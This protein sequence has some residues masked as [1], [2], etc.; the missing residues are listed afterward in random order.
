[1]K[2][3]IRVAVIVISLSCLFCLP[4]FGQE[5]KINS[6]VKDEVTKQS[7]TALQLIK[8]AKEKRYDSNAIIDS[9]L[10]LSPQEKVKFWLKE[11]SNKSEIKDAMIVAGLDAVPYLAD[12]VRYGKGEQ[13]SDA[14]EILCYMDR[15]I[16]D[17]DLLLPVFGR[18]IYVK[19]L[20]IRGGINDYLPIDGRRIGNEGVDV[21]KWAAE[22]TEDKALNFYARYF[23]GRLLEELRSTPIREVYH[24]WR[25]LVIKGKGFLS[26]AINIDVFR[27]MFLCGTVLAENAPETLPF[28]IEATQ[29]KNPYIRERAI[30]VIASIDG[31][32]MRLRKSE[33]GKR[34]IEAVR[35]AL[36]QGNLK[37]MYI[38]RERREE[39]WQW[40][41][42]HIF[43][44]N[45]PLHYNSLWAIYALAM[46]TFYGVKTTDKDY[47]VTLIVE[48][49]PEFR[50]FITYLTDIDP[51]F[52]SWDFYTTG[53]SNIQ[54]HPR[55]RQ[56]VAHL[57]EYWKKFKAQQK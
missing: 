43:E 56:K 2:S 54:A 31:I 55:F 14:V 47:T 19:P 15:F 26:I 51:Y 39:S 36:E 46:E 6:Q 57:Y 38:N 13:R 1:M 17:K 27:L 42:S 44:D 34:A 33:I 9:F 18:S 45:Y 21:I 5:V 28:L 41:Y 3:V 8:E 40:F 24:Q 4:I 29:D 20:N 25:L 37:P 16:Q 49:T 50:Q 10:K 48:A 7:I 23:S 30:G 12:V 22:Q 53:G 52:P 11:K 32:K 35:Q